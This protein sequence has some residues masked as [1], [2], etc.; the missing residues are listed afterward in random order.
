MRFSCPMCSKAS[1]GFL[2]PDTVDCWI[3]AVQT[4]QYLIDQFESVCRIKF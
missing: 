1:H 3:M 2:L 4:V